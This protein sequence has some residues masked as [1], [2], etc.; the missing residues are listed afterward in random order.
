MGLGVGVMDPLIDISLFY[1][2]NQFF[3]SLELRRPS[4]NHLHDNKCKKSLDQNIL[5]EPTDSLQLG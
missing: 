3:F 4:E 1:L 2:R 5:F